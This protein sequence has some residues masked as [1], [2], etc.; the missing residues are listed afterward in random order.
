MNKR[1]NHFLQ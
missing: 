1:K